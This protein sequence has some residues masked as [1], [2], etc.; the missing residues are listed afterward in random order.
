MRGTVTEIMSQN[1]SDADFARIAELVER[2]VGIHLPD[3]KRSMVELRVARRARKLGMSGL[4][5]YC[6]FVFDPAGAS[7]EQNQLIDIITT[8]KT[9]FFRESE[10]FDRLT[11]TV[12]PELQERYPDLGGARPFRVWSAGCSTGE[13]PYTISM[14]L[15][16][17]ASAH[18][19]FRF[20]VRA[21][22]VSSRALRE[23]VRA[24]YA[25]ERACTI[26]LE[27]RREYLLRHKDHTIGTVRVAPEIRSRV[28][29]ARHNLFTDPPAE[30]GKFDVIF[31]RNVIIYF[32][33]DNQI[34]VLQMLADSLV[35]G[36]YI[37]VG[38]SETLHGMPLPLERIGP[39]L[40]RKV[41]R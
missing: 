29:F 18:P 21:T 20:E 35:P 26:P 8:N 40:Y 6:E 9:D 41:V 14:V 25:E 38:H 17:H 2:C 16:A 23:A 11:E 12:L 13:E 36:G 3:H 32:Q 19:G 39:T 7:V 37:F 5:S 34:K 15:S 28:T 27:L 31:C 10:H 4:D 30:A 1:L 33:R 24:V 22:D